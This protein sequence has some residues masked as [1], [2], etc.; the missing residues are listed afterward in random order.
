M[1]IF[2]QSLFENIIKL[3]SS[4]KWNDILDI[5]VVT[6][7]LYYFIKLFRQTRAIN[8]VKGFVLLGVCYLLVSALN[9][10]TSTYLFSR[11]FNDIVI[12]VILLFQPEIRHAVESVGRGDFKKLN[13]FSTHST[14]VTNEQLR[15]SASHIAKAACDMSEKKIGALIVIEGKSPVGEI[16]STGSTVDSVVS[17]E[18]IKNIFF[19]KAPLH[20]G[21][22][23]ISNNR[24]HSAGCILPL[25]SNEISK[26]LGTRH[27]AALG[28]S[29]HYDSLVVVV[30]EE[31]GMISVAQDSRLMKNLSDG[32]LIEAITNFLIDEDEKEKAISRSKRRKSADEK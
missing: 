22:I 3:V 6:F 2:F 5:V 21:A 13:I 23:V 8:L 1:V 9:M 16:V 11:I 10:S 32:E 20:D 14:K 17:A 12:V 30:S 27:R 19:P 31:T 15:A 4:V 29:E 7:V 28:M 18:V 25:T 24:I 26:D